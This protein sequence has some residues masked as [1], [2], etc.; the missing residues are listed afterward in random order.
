MKTSS[1]A[2]AK[3]AEFEGCRLDAYLDPVG[4]PTIGCGHTAGVQLGDHITHEQAMTYLAEDT[5]SAERA[6]D[7][8]GL[9]LNQHQF[10]A[11]VSFTFNCGAGN[12][13]KLVKGRSLAQIAD[14]I[15]K[16]NKAGGRVLTGLTR[17]RT[18]ERDWFLSESEKPAA[19]QKKDNPYPVPDKVLRRGS[20]GV[21]VRWLQR[22]LVNDGYEI[23]VDGIF[24]SIT[25]RCVKD[26]QRQNHLVVDGLVGQRTISALLS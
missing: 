9:P 8:V 20:K 17:R 4:I 2:L 13:K 12:L 6:V 24:G 16:Y 5:R 10:D 23:Q 21:T 18:W 25:E 3:I 14:A 22:E 19:E 1:A 7:A 26:F 15:P 11:L